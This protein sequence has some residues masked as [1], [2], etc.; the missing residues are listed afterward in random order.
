MV[1]ENCKIKKNKVAE[2]HGT[3]QKPSTLQYSLPFQSVLLTKKTK[4]IST[5]AP[6]VLILPAG[7]GE[8]ITSLSL[9]KSIVKDGGSLFS[10]HPYISVS[11]KICTERKRLP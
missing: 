6:L 2:L 9:Q 4:N 5:M 7:T 11:W 3:A 1:S 8:R 10:G